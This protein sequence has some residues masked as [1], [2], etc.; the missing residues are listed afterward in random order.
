MYKSEPRP[1]A[2]YSHTMDE[3]ESMQALAK[4]SL[5][6]RCLLCGNPGTIRGVFIPTSKKM[7]RLFNIPKGKRRLIAYQ[8]CEGCF[9][10]NNKTELIENKL[11]EAA[12]SVRKEDLQWK[13]GTLR[14]L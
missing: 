10:K 6:I 12:L 3:S 11:M 14:T 7:L 5:P 13:P 4:L 2:E 9:N 1:I 8:L